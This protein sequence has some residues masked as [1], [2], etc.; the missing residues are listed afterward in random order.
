MSRSKKL[1]KGISSISGQIDL[2]RAK[3]EEAERVGNEELA[4]YYGKEIESLKIYMEKK[5]RQ[6]GKR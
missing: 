2:H 5:K 6:L 4:A 3:K 1:R